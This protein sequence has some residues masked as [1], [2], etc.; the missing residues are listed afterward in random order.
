VTGTPLSTFLALREAV[1]RQAPAQ[2]GLAL[3]HALTE[4][5]DAALCAIA[6]PATAGAEALAL[7][8]VGGY[9]RRELCLCSDIDLMLLH[10]GR[11]APSSVERVFYPLWDAGLKVGHAVRSV[12]EAVTAADEE[13]KT[14][15][16]L[17][18]AR[19]VA[20]DPR[21]LARL[22][23]EFARLLRRRGDRL[24]AALAAAERGVREAEPYQLLELNLKEGR[25][26]LRSL[27]RLRWLRR[28]ET[29]GA[30]EAATDPDAVPPAAEAAL[31]ILLSARNALH[32]AAGRAQEVWLF[33]LQ[34]QAAAW[35][36]DDR[37]AFAVRLYGAAR[38][39]DRLAERLLAG[40]A[41][42]QSRPAPSAGLRGVLRRAAPAGRRVPA[43]AAPIPRPPASVLAYAAG[44]ADG[45]GEPMAL[46]EP[47]A[48][49]IAAAPGPAWSAADR[50]GLLAL[51][52]AG[53]RGYAIFARLDELGWIERA[54]PEW[55]HVRAAPQHV[56]FHRHPV[57]VHLWRTAIEA[58][59]LA[60]GHRDEPWFAEVGRDLGAL[61]DLLLAALLHDIGKG[62]PGDHAVRGAEAAAAFCRR[63]RFPADFIV[64]VAG[65]VRHHLLL[66][67]VATRRDIADPRVV[68]AVA[69]SAGSERT[70]RI[71]FLLAAADSIAT[72]PG[73]WTPW[74]S[75]LVRSLF[76]AALAVLEARGQANPLLAG[77]PELRERL[78]SS[79]AEEAERVTLRRHL[80]SMAPGYIQSFDPR[81]ILRHAAIMVAPL[82][83]HTVRLDVRGDGPVFEL[84]VALRDRPGLIALTSGVLA[85]HNLSVLGARFF[86]R[87]DGVAL[88]SLH[89]VDALGNAV[90]PER[91]A[92]VERD[93]QAALTGRLPL[94]QRLEEKA[95]AYRRTRR[96]RE[97]EVL[98]VA[99]D[100]REFTVVEVHA[101]DRVGLLYSLTSS[102]FELGVDIH[103]AKID[104]QGH[105]AVDVFYLREA[106]DQPLRGAERI[107]AVRAA[108]RRAAAIP[109]AHSG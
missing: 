27:Q 4:A 74:K 82:D 60:E 101:E 81:E 64:T 90:T 78:L 94:A 97:P 66:P 26:G 72:G 20:G 75:S 62:W 104:T 22:T 5:L 102:L 24:R 23:E 10:G 83:D 93:L 80:D 38:I 100:A 41:F 88:Q 9:G 86:T 34:P 46:V 7:V 49:A 59:R 68:E 45:S 76:V 61:D 98:V 30:R 71:L 33:D 63:A 50:A 47:V 19:L 87:D 39:V 57:D 2:P 8:A 89:V 28:I 96:G 92:R 58:L 105:D 108:L 25:G 44:L 12:P 15:T 53:E 51:L 17:L 103:L 54:L 11:L 77:P 109:A 36:G 73:I 37:D 16:A 29:A 91:W 52:R 67:N 6:A 21:L 106:N 43:A 42:G 31:D 84:I 55:R 99:T 107:E 65:A 14:L 69:A 18:D 70:L 3:C 48:T 35:L 1:I 13:L 56:P 40:P 85:L 95:R 79:V 32:A